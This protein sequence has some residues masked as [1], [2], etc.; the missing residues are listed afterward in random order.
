MIGFVL[1]AAPY[2]PLREETIAELAGV[3]GDLVKM[4]V[5]SLSSLLYRDGEANGGIR[6][7][8]LSISDFF[9]SHDC[10]RDYHVSFQDVNVELG[11]SCLNTMVEQLR[12]NIA[13]SKIPESR[14]RPFTISH[15][16]SR[17]IFPT[18]CS[19]VVCIGQIM[20]ALTQEIAISVFGDA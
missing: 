3:G 1:T 16:E 6:V 5:E 12:F 9:L 13:S 18:L 17:R 19:I 10:H 7:R 4:W 8:H 14:M 2:R 20:F 11:I 15:C